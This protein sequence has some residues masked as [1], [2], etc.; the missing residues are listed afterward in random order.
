M[1][2]IY[3][4]EPSIEDGHQTIYIGVY[5]NDELQRIAIVGGWS[6]F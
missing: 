4:Y 5:E 2:T 1:D 3:G 6:Q